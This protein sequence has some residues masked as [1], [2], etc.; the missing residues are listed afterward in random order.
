M[1]F[2]TVG[3]QLAF[4]RMINV[5]NDW[6]EINPS[7]KIIAQVGPSNAMF[8]YLNC[9]DFLPPDL[10]NQYFKDARIIVAH[11]GMGSVLT[12]LKY[13]K[14]IIIFPRKASLGEHR[15]EHQLAT[16]RWLEKKASIFVAWD[17][18]KLI[19]LLDRSHSLLSGDGF[20]EYANAD[21]IGNLA[22]FINS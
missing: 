17:E 20:T 12:A 8:D 5:L 19:E 3:T 16:A 9:H 22:E 2:A 14:P 10:S 18:A 7:E 13:H 15:N 21:L 1:I 4:D 6:A 11:A